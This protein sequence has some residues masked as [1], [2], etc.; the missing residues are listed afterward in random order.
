MRRRSTAPTSRSRSAARPP[1]SKEDS[2]AQ[3]IFTIGHSNHPLERF[4]DL[5]RMHAIAIV[6]DVRSFPSS[7]KWPHF[8]QP[9]LSASLAHAGIQYLWMQ[10]LGGRRRST[11]ADSPH[12]GWQHPAFRAYADHTESADFQSALDELIATAA[13]APTAYMCSEGLWWQCHRRIISDHLAI[14]GV[15][16]EHIMPDGKLKPHVVAPFARIA[17]GKI[18][19][20]GQSEFSE[21]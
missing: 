18:V 6:A 14:R 16:V 10:Q 12:T 20:D 3:H 15:T 2:P 5:L 17:A 21:K 11:R 4:L 13:H 7:R 8:N 1:R 19:Y 9:E